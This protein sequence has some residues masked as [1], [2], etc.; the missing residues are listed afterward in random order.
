MQ[1]KMMN[2]AAISG[3]I[4]SSTS[5][6]VEDRLVLDRELLRLLSLFEQYFS[7][8]KFFGRLIK[9]D[10]IECVLEE[11]Q[12]ALRSA[13]L[14]KSF[15]KQISFAGNKVLDKN[16]RKYGI[17]IA[18][19]IGEL[20]VLDKE[21][22]IIDGEAIYLSGRAVNEMS[23]A[24]RI[25]ETLAFRSANEAWNEPLTPLFKLLD[26]L[27]AGYTRA[28]SEI[29]FYKLQG[30]TEMEI[31]RL[32]KKGQSTVNQHV[33]SVDWPAVESALNYFERTIR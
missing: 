6:N 5:L 23:T 8:D 30:K 18:I 27:F 15:V 12:F 7:E 26:Y 33:Q 13:L 11:P 4:V 16:F 31:A 32:L 17:R 1:R 19:G 24:D 14:M 20:N 2:K 29:V 28:Q 22:G 21:K 10:Y 25:K 3:D 9:G